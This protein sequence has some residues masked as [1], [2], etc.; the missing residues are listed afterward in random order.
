MNIIDFSDRT[1]GIT[2]TV[3][4]SGDSLTVGIGTVGLAAILSGRRI[5]NSMGIGGQKTQQIAARMGSTPLYVTATLSGGSDVAC[6]VNIPFLSTQADNTTRQIWGT[7]NGLKYRITR[8]ATGTA[9]SQVETYT[10][11]PGIN[12][13]NSII[14]GLF[15]P[16]DSVRVN[17]DINILWWGRNDVGLSSLNDVPI[18]IQNYILRL[19]KPRRVLVQGVLNGFL[20]TIGTS[21]YNAIKSVNDILR[22]T[23]GD[24]YVE[25][26]PPTTQEATAIGY[27]LTTQDIAEIA[28]GVFPSSMRS[29]NTHLNAYGYNFIDYRQ[30]QKI[31]QLGW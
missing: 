9:P 12:A 29:D 30:A 25:T 2:N 28:N 1:Q 7:I 14:N 15:I 11:T 23:Y 22:T 27:T 21:N 10:I 8:T 13:T 16:D 6:T 24:H 5:I 3:T 4:R 20:E 18:Y 31:M 26:T 19:N 17:D